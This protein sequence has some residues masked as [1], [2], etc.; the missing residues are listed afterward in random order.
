MIIIKDK[1]YLDTNE[2]SELLREARQTL[3]QEY[4]NRGWDR[5]KYGKRIYFSKEQ[6]E[7]FME[8]KFHKI[9]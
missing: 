7:T 2:A 6:I 8:E 3:L 5:Y 4:K 9:D 1:E